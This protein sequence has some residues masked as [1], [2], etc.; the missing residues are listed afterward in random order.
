MPCDRIQRSRER[1]LLHLRGERLERGEPAL[2]VVAFNSCFNRSRTV[3]LSFLE[4]QPHQVNVVKR[5]MQIELRLRVQDRLRVALQLLGRL[6]V[7]EVAR[8]FVI[9]HDA[10]VRIQIAE[11]RPLMLAD[12]RDFAFERGLTGQCGVHIRQR[13]GGHSLHRIAQI[14]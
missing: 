7:L 8:R 13:F 12:H 14:R 4:I 1:R 3:G 2:S 5:R 9:P 10:G 6:A 11:A